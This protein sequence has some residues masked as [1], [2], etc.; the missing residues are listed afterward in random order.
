MKELINK[1]A[2][3]LANIFWVPDFNLNWKTESE[4]FKNDWN[5]LARHV[6]SQ[7]IKA[8]IEERTAG[9]HHGLCLGCKDRINE[10]ES[11]LKELTDERD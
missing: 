9:L 11:Q 1:K 5:K 6:L 10:L 8:R 3:E 2:E 7:E 4:S